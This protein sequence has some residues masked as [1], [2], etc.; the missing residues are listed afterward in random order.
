[1]D[2]EV[3]DKEKLTDLFDRLWPICRSI[4]G[5]GFRKSLDI[6][7]SLIPFEKLSFASDLSVFDWNVP[8]EWNVKDA[9]ILH[10]NGKKMADFK[11]NNLHLVGYSIPFKGKISLT[12]LKKHLHSLPDQ[13]Q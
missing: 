11:K 1:M 3:S 13:P 9:Y 4:T 5:E 10:P 2:K 8:K 7:S 12:E 6:L